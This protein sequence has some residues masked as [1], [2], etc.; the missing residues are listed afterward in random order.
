MPK[1]I[2]GEKSTDSGLE[3]RTILHIHH[4]STQLH[5]PPHEY[6][7]VL[8][9]A[10]SDG[11]VFCFDISW[12]ENGCLARGMCSRWPH[13]RGYVMSPGH[14]ASACHEV[15]SQ[16]S[17]QDKTVL[18]WTQDS[19]SALGPRRCSRQMP[20]PM[21][22]GVSNS[23]GRRGES[24][25]SQSMVLNPLMLMLEWHNNSPSTLKPSSLLSAVSLL[26]CG[27]IGALL[28][29]ANQ[30]INTEIYEG[31]GLLQHRGQDAA[32]IITCGQK[33][34][35]YQCK[36]NGM[37]RD[38]FNPSQL[39]SLNG[40]LTNAD[41]LREFLD[42]DAHRHVNTEA[43]SELLLNIFAN[44]LQQTG[45]TNEED[46]FAALTKLMGNA[47]EVMHALR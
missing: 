44:N 6:G 42:Q 12:E 5:G 15:I 4:L 38:V 27:I 28:S 13:G 34:R 40:N 10:S 29:D 24:E 35:L 31:L 46:I 30:A 16:S 37:V 18:I 32:G 8:A 14:Q 21:W 2:S 20:S 45:K 3:L 25:M 39:S 11:K 22:C 17:S 47:V 41:E 33:G 43:D 36:A 26:M 1:S 7:L 9:A 19:P 23:S